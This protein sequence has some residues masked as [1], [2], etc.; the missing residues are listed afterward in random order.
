[1]NEMSQDRERIAAEE[2]ESIKRADPDEFR[3]GARRAFQGDKLYPPGFAAG[4]SIAATLGSPVS[5]SAMAIASAPRAAMVISPIFFSDAEWQEW[6]RAHPDLADRKVIQFDKTRKRKKPPP[7]P[8]PGG[9]PAWV[10]RLRR[11]DRGRVIADLANVLIALR[12]EESVYLGVAFDEMLQCPIVT[13]VWPHTPEAQ[14]IK[15]APHEVGDDD[16]NRLQE[17]LQAFGLPRVSR[18]TVR[19]AVE[20]IAVEHSFHPL[21]DWL[22]SLE[23]DGEPQ[24]GSWLHRCLGTPDDEYPPSDRLVVP[25]RHGRPNLRARLQVRLHARSGRA[26]GRRKIKVLHRAGWRRRVLFRIPASKSTAMRCASRC[27]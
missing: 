3:D 4:R 24:I 21:R 2:R 10:S 9:W 13:R 27:I 15:A 6:L 22:D 19:Q 23:H 26:A 11:D 5:T 20:M 18:E 12:G 17:W 14:P 1:M 25:D 7:Q 8:P 16:V